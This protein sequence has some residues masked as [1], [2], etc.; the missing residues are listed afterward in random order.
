MSVQQL[1]TFRVGEHILGVDVELV[2][3]VFRVQKI[4]RVPLAA[5]AIGGLINLRGQVIT[6]IDLRT[7]LGLPPRD[8]DEMPATVIVR[9]ETGPVSLLVDAVSAVTD[10]TGAKYEPAPGTIPESSRELVDGCYKLDDKLLLA[11]DLGRAVDT[12]ATV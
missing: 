11:L 8:A 5:G 12:Y 2:Q 4:T 7:R 9:R 1:A 10:V 3:E 6:A